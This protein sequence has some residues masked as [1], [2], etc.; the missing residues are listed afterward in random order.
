TCSDDGAGDLSHPALAT[1]SLRYVLAVTVWFPWAGFPIRPGSDRPDWK[2]GPRKPDSWTKHVYQ[3]SGG[4]ERW[5]STGRS[6]TTLPVFRSTAL[7]LRGVTSSP[8]PKTGR[9]CPP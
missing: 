8:P 1:P 9:P 5:P 2:S 3:G 6:Q 4:R 7:T